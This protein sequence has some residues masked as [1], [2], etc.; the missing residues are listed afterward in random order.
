M[1]NTEIFEIDNGILIHHNDLN[2]YYG[3]NVT[4]PDGITSI[5][6]AAFKYNNNLTNI[7][8]PSSLSIISN[9]AF[10]YCKN[11][12]N[13]QLPNNLSF[14]GDW[15]FF[16]CN[17]LIIHGYDGSYAQE[18]AKKYK[19]P[20]VV[21][22][23]NKPKNTTNYIQNEDDFEIVNKVLIRY[24][25]H[26]ETVIIPD[27]IISISNKAFYDC[28]NLVNVQ[29]PN[30]LISIENWA[31]G[32]CKN[33]IN[34]NLPDNLSSIGKEAFGHCK[35][36]NNIKFPS[37]LK[38]IGDNAFQY[39]ESL[40]NIQFPDNLTNIGNWIFK[41]CKNLTI[42]GYAESYAQKYAME[43]RTPFVIIGEEKIKNTSMKKQQKGIKLVLNTGNF[44]MLEQPYTI[45]T[46]YICNNIVYLGDYFK[47]NLENGLIKNGH[48]NLSY[49]WEEIHSQNAGLIGAI[50]NTLCMCVQIW[51][52]VMPYQTQDV[53]NSLTAQ[54]N[55]Y[56]KQYELTGKLTENS[57]KFSY[58]N[59]SITFEKIFDIIPADAPLEESPRE[60]MELYIKEQWTLCN[61]TLNQDPAPSPVSTLPDNTTF[62]YES[63]Y[64]CPSCGR[65]LNKILIQSD[66]HIRVKGEEE[67]IR[68]VFSCK[69]CNEFFAQFRLNPLG[70][71][72][73]FHL[74]VNKQRYNEI[75]L[76]LDACGRQRQF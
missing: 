55:L 24:K 22:G 4:V 61:N 19:I 76:S 75:A 27:G 34:I 47:V 64:I 7:Q 35:N 37:N 45:E 25:G 51:K 23:E 48:P 17:N 12:T 11:L 41:G 50:A 54:M 68:T 15:A 60:F 28:N 39:C 9:W 65:K 42:Y 5:G 70:S 67:S 13:I 14:I 6:H 66:S 32:Y 30:S 21:I 38:N 29:L 18:Y 3:Y 10:G 52:G 8:F 74:K 46:I 26:S 36:L 71:G 56:L 16:G 63:A 73:Y 44:L 53:C 58:K 31:F 59:K 72:K 49:Q 62:F 40:N 20:F 57:W 1:N 69:Y 43:Y 33:L 2:G